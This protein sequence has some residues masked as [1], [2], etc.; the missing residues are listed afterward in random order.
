M[1]KFNTLLFLFGI[2]IGLVMPFILLKLGFKPSKIFFPGRRVANF[3]NLK[4]RH[5]LFFANEVIGMYSVFFTIL[6]YGAVCSILFIVL[7]ILFK[8]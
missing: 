8:K 2:T 4:T 7:N 6:I 1:T 3:L 5:T